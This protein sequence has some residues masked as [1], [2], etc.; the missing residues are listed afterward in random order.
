MKLFLMLFLWY[1]GLFWGYFEASLG[2]V[3]LFVIL[4][5][6]II[7][8]LFW[9]YVWALLSYFYI[10]FQ[11]IVVYSNICLTLCLSTCLDFLGYVD[12]ILML[13][14]RYVGLFL[15][16]F[17]VTLKPWFPIFDDIVEHI[18]AYFWLFWRYFWIFSQQQG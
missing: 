10:I 4:F 13:F 8:N 7:L 3:G 18:L 9:T 1:S 2:Y 16:N 14:L 17:E 15:C 12:A 6:S 11:A 5:F